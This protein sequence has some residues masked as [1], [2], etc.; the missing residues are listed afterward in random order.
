MS[1]RPSVLRAVLLEDPPYG[2]SSFQDDS[3][4]VWQIYLIIKRWVL[5]T[6]NHP[7]NFLLHARLNIPVVGQFDNAPEYSHIYC[8]RSTKTHIPKDVEQVLWSYSGPWSSR[9]RWTNDGSAS[10]DLFSSTPLSIPFSISS[11]QRSITAI[12]FRYTGRKRS[13]G[14]MSIDWSMFSTYSKAESTIMR[15]PSPVV[16]NRCPNKTLI[17][18]LD[19]ACTMSGFG[20]KGR[21]L[22]RWN[23]S[24]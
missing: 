14:A 22:Y 1:W 15:H 9:K 4:R 8:A 6:W 18:T 13:N 12:F 5:V 10:D 20:L 17:M 7:I 2:A 21:P 23:S 11:M 16:R 24:T 19:T 3:L